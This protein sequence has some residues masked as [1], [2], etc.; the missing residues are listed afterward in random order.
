VKGERGQALVELIAGLPIMVTLGLSLLQLLAAGYSAVLAGNAAEA[1]A[2]AIAG[3][4]DPRS[5]ARG[6]LPGWSEGRA[7][8]EVTGRTAVVRLRPPSPLDAVARH[9]EVERRATVVLP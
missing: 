1:A 5:A 7:R 8:L 4:V 9:L 6:A 3:E 2:L